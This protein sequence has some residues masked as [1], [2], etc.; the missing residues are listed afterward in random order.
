MK[1][2]VV[3]TLIALASCTQQPDV[4]CPSIEMLVQRDAAAD[5]RAALAKDDHH[6]L[7]LGGYEGEVPGVPDAAA[8]PTR[9]FEGTSDTTT[10]ACYRQRG[11]A[12]AYATKYNQTIVQRH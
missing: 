11:E 12:E 3:A 2:A 5:A 9:M 6:L 8:Y 1:A 4:S 10:E 7:M